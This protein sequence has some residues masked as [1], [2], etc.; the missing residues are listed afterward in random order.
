MYGNRTFGRF[1][2]DVRRQVVEPI[3]N[4]GDVEN[5]RPRR[6]EDHHDFIR[7]ECHLLPFPFGLL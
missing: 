5:P 2:G 3:L 1:F 6:T 7:L 4:R